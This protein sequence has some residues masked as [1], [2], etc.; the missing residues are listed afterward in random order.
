MTVW[1]EVQ[2]TIYRR[3]VEAWSEAGREITP[4]QFDNEKMDPPDGPWVRLVVRGR[5]GGPGTI[6]RPGNRRMDR[7]GVVFIDLREPPG[8]GVGHVSDLAERARGVFEDRRFG[9]YDIRFATVDIGG[10]SEIDGGRWWGVTVE[11]RFDFEEFK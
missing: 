10:E 1:R 7:V 2:E 8:S 11:A 6:G 4:T 9:P 3:W 5:P